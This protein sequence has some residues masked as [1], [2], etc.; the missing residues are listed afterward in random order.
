[1][2]FFWKSIHLLLEHLCTLS[3]LFQETHRSKDGCSC[4]YRLTYE[5]LPLLLPYVSKRILYASPVDFHRL[6]QYRTINFAHF[7]DARLG[8]EAAFLTPGCCVV[9]LHDEGHEN[10]RSVSIDPSTIAIVCW[11]GKGTMNVMVSPP[12]RKELLERIEYRFRFKA[13]IEEDEK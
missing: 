7:V 3:I 8:E 10:A 12:D 2:H 5:G 4:P 9:V 13:A 11:R 1:M 6:L